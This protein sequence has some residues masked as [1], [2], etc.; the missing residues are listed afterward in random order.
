M[1][2]QYQY[3]GNICI[4]DIT[5]FVEHLTILISIKYDINICVSF[6]AVQSVW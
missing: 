4:S 3:A 1:F 2:T 5:L 6:K